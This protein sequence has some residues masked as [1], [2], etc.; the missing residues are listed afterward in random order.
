MKLA[1][2]LY[3]L[4]SWMPTCFKL[5][6]RWIR[7][8]ECTPTRYEGGTVISWEK[9]SFASRSLPNHSFLRHSSLLRWIEGYYGL[10]KSFSGSEPGMEMERLLLGLK[11]TTEQCKMLRPLGCYTLCLFLR[12]NAGQISTKNVKSVSIV[13]I[14]RCNGQILGCFRDVVL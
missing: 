7:G 13:C 4:L 1:F 11:Y 2:I 6:C 8:Q 3:T 10:T 12:W 9:S 5:H 14:F